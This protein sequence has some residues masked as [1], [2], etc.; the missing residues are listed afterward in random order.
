MMVKFCT[1]FKLLFLENRRSVVL[2]H[3]KILHHLWRHVSHVHLVVMARTTLQTL[4]ALSNHLEALI[5]HISII[6]AADGSGNNLL[7]CMSESRK[8]ITSDSP[9]DVLA[10]QMGQLSLEYRNVI[11]EG[12]A[13][14]QASQHTHGVGLEL[15]GQKVVRVDA[16]EQTLGLRSIV[17]QGPPQGLSKGLSA[18][19]LGVGL[20]PLGLELDPAELGAISTHRHDHTSEQEQLPQHDDCLTSGLDR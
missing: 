12:E 11:K 7:E 4:D 14:V 15:G 8:L 1:I 9:L 3:C 17:E 13:H 5:P 19:T 18:G 10:L 20:G 6:T 2:S 16:G